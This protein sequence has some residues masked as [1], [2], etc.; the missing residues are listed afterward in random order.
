MQCRDRLRRSRRSMSR[1][2]TS[3]TRRRRPRIRCTMRVMPSKWSSSTCGSG[4]DPVFDSM[5]TIHIVWEYPVRC[6]VGSFM[7]S[8]PNRFTCYLQESVGGM[9]YKTWRS[10]ERLRASITVRSPLTSTIILHIDNNTPMSTINDL[11]LEIFSRVE[12]WKMA[13]S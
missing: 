11:E 7:F 8:F 9:D 12:K 4:A 13:T 6:L 5:L 3:R 1:I 2:L 10:L